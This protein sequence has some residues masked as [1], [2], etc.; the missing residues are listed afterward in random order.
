MAAGWIVR[1][2]WELNNGI[3]SNA[4][5]DAYLI[6]NGG[7]IVRMLPGSSTTLDATT[8]SLVAGDLVRITMEDNG[9]NVTIKGYKNGV[10][11]LTAIDTNALRVT[12]GTCGLYGN[13]VGG[14]NPTVNHCDYDLFETGKGLGV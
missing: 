7:T 11:T 9:S 6:G 5:A 4:I 12:V 1:V 3:G 14:A 10:L 2:N 8:W 13:S